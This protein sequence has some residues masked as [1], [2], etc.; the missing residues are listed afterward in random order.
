LKLINKGILDSSQEY[1][2]QIDESIA[3]LKKWAESCPDNFLYQQ[4]LLEAELENLNGKF[5]EASSLFCQAIDTAEKYQIKHAIALSSELLSEFWDDHGRQEQADFYLRAAATHYSKWGALYKSSILL[6]RIDPVYSE[7]TQLVQE[8]TQPDPYVDIQTNDLDFNS[9][10]KFTQAISSEID[11]D[12][13]LNKSM[14][15]IVENSGAERGVLVSKIEGELEVSLVAEVY[16]KPIM[17]PIN[18]KLD[19]FHDIPGNIIRYVERTR[20]VVL[21][22]DAQPS[23]FFHDLLYVRNDIMHSVL[24]LP[25]SYKNELLAI[26]Y[27]EN[28]S[29]RGVF[30]ERRTLTLQILLAQLAISLQ[31]SKLY[32]SLENELYKN[33]Q[34]S[35]A[36]V[37]S[38]ETLRLSHE[39]ANVGAWDWDIPASNLYWSDSIYPLLGYEVGEIEA[40]LDNFIL[41]THPD[42]RKKVEDAINICFAT[43]EKYQVEHRIVWP[44]GTERW[45]LESG[46]VTRDE[47]NN[48]IRMLGIAKDITD[49]KHDNDERHRLEKQLQQSQKMEAI[50]LLTGGI[51]HDFNN[52]IQGISGFTEILLL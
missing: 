21:L 42:D 12:K 30:N 29:I 28:N 50:G 18:V 13:L 25:V 26:V 7:S 35:N 5:W 36:L 33:K 4:L 41:V 19:D 31:N 39:Y 47:S 51:A 17:T 43:G 46:N 40:S 23:N 14:S 49:I 45:I 32:R 37:K 15:I 27:L 11:N 6:T 48:P 10:L 52:I 22:D 20:E 8:V 24:C 3:K 2:E 1:L 9:I 44:D 38:D 34:I 16:D